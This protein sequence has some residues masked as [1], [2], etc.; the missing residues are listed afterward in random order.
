MSDDLTI[1][2]PAD[3]DRTDNGAA[4]GADSAGVTPA[5]AAPQLDQTES[6]DLFAPGALAQDEQA[7]LL[8]AVLFSA[9]EVVSAERLTEYFGIDAIELDV[10]AAEAAGS[11]R[12]LGLDILAAAGGFKL[13]TTSIW[14]SYLR[15]FHRKLRRARLSKGALEILAVI[16]YEQPVTRARVD[17]LRQVNSEGPIRTLLDKRIITVAGRADTPGRPFLYRTTAYFLEIFGLDSLGDLPPRPASLDKATGLDLGRQD[18]AE[19]AGLDELPGF[20]MDLTGDDE[21]AD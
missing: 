2:I 5:A 6:E 21:L 19:P 12:P 17:E 8:T 14:D 3:D 15:N 16:A 18:D 1:Y 11:L 10:L 13:V 7:G 9:G 4:S 20:D